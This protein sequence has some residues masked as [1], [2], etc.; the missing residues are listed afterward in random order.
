[1]DV[2]EDK[3]LIIL[4][5]AIGDV[6]LATPSIA[7]F[8]KKY[9]KSNISFLVGKWSAPILYNNPKVDHLVE[10]DD[11]SFYEKQVLPLLTLIR[12][13]RKEKY[14]L[15]F[16]LQ[17]SRIWSLFMALVG[18]KAGFRIGKKQ[19]ERVQHKVERFLS[20][21]QLFDPEIKAGELEIFPDQ[22][23]EA[24]AESIINK[25]RVVALCVGGGHNPGTRTRRKRWPEARFVELAKKIKQSS[26]A[27]LL[28]VGGESD[29]NATA[30][31]IS[32][33]DFKVIDKTGET[34]LLQL[35]ALLK[36]S[37]ALVTGD[38]GPMHIG[39]AAKTTVI[40]LMGP[41]DPKQTGPFG[42]NAVVL[43]ENLSCSPCFKDDRS[44]DEC[45]LNQ[46][47]MNNI[48]V[49]AVYSALRTVLKNNQAAIK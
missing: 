46:K 29:K 23:D 49:D 6:L 2:R 13:L 48:T 43:Y 34:T 31:V 45:K 15:V 9:P 4:L 41:T 1:M 7:G 19:N 42:N 18:A 36:R 20:V 10:S 35:A 21:F 12:R 5:G 39:I 16:C 8:K 14:D 44:F 26:R 11:A 24:M 32:K 33:L 47:C 28:F 3:I 17:R 40:A 25:K 37:L 38:T 22:K 27:E 30:R